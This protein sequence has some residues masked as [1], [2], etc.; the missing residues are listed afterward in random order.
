M[1]VEEAKH[2][3]D[4]GYTHGFLVESEP[5]VIEVHPLL[6]LFLEEKLSQEA[7]HAFETL[8]TRAFNYRV[9]RQNW[10][11]RHLT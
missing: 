5:N 6:Q 7:P 11:G 1:G 3:I 8:V 4:V 10:D 9:E 2:A